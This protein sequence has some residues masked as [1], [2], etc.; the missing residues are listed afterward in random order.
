MKRLFRWLRSHPILCSVATV[1]VAAVLL[2]AFLPKPRVTK[3]NYE[4]ITLGMAQADLH[5]LLGIPEYQTQ[6]PD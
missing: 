4:R 3:A 5:N 1:L 2:F 6:D